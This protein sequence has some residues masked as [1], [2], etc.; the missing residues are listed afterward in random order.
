MFRKFFGWLF[1]DSDRI[2][3]YKGRTY[4]CDG[5]PS[6]DSMSGKDDLLGSPSLSFEEEGIL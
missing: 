1:S 4:E 3:H 5:M 6:F 2:S